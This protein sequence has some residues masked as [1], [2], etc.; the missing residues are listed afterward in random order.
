MGPGRRLLFGLLALLIGF[1]L[2]AV[3]EPAPISPVE[4]TPPPPAPPLAPNDRLAKV[5]LLAPN[6]EGPEAVTFDA[7]GRLLTGTKDGRVVRFEAD[8][9]LTQLADTG[10]RPLGLEYG[11]D[12]VLY[13]CDAKKGLL[14]LDADGGLAELATSEGGDPFRF[15]D[16]LSIAKD[17]TVYFTDA[18]ARNSIDRFVDDLIEHRTTGRLL[19]YSPATRT[20]K[21]LA[22]GFSFSNGVALSPDEQWVVLAETGTYRLWKIA[23]RGEGAGKKEPFG[24]PLPGFPDNVTLDPATGRFYVAVGSPR[25]RMMDALAGAPRVRALVPRLP[26]SW[27]PKP[28]RVG[29]VLV[30]DLEGKLVDS[31]QHHH[32]ES[33]SPIASAEVRDGWLYLGSFARH[34]LARLRLPGP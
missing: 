21:S 20:V 17:G 4:W 1:L 33:Y 11:P 8:G 19:E 28:E 34:G 26:Q 22:A 14:G 10:G 12:G 9:G 5:E 25:N 18:S 16:D 3:A 30:Y 7:E 23:V 27:R 2:W 31:L 24:D 13:I 32:P 15:V 29:M 6:L